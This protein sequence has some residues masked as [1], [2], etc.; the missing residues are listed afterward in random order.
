[1]SQ[2]EWLNLA[3]EAHPGRYDYTKSVYISATDTVEIKCLTCGSIF[4]QQAYSHIRLRCGCPLCA[5]SK[6][7][8][9]VSDILD[10]F[11]VNIVRQMKFDGCKY[12]RCLPFD[13]YLPDH[14][15]CIEVHGRQHYEPILHFGG[16]K[17]LKLTQKRDR[18]KQRYCERSNI[19]LEII[20][21]WMTENEVRTVVSRIAHVQ[22]AL[23]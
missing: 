21:Y 1:M 15:V 9:L 13:F 7:E 16:E 10:Q 4:W 2:D 8:Q 22:L 18:I 5:T 12:K 3:R 19:K 6:G 17:S 23:F 20:P 14:N 11:G